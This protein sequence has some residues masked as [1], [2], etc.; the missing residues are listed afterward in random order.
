MEAILGGAANVQRILRG[1]GGLDSASPSSSV[2]SPRQTRGATPPDRVAPTHEIDLGELIFRHVDDFCAA[3]APTEDGTVRP[4]PSAA[5]PR[6]SAFDMHL[7][8]QAVEGEQAP[9]NLSR[10]PPSL[11]A[12]A[13]DHDAWYRRDTGLLAA[14]IQERYS[15]IPPVM[16]NSAWH[17]GISHLYTYG[18]G[19]Y[20]YL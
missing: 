14:A 10:K 7:P 20:S 6:P 13:P 18:G 16:P 11:S 4:S 1:E 8:S 2:P 9:R 15:L 19:Y 17:G 12:R 3:G 5:T